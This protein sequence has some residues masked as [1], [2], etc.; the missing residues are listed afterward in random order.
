MTDAPV[1]FDEIGYWSELKLEIIK[2]YGE[3][4]TKAFARHPTLKKLY[5]DGFSGAGVHLSKKTKQQ[6][7]GSP[8]LALKVS[9]PFDAFY[10]VDM[11]SE[12]IAYLRKLCQGRSDVH[13]H[14]GI[15]TRI[16]QHNYCRRSGIR[17]TSAPCACSIPTGC[18]SI[19]GHA[20]SR[21][22]KGNRHVSQFPCHGHE[23]ERDLAY[24]GECPARR[25]RTHEPLLGGRVMARCCLCR[26]RPRQ[27]F[28]TRT[29]QTGQ[30][31]DCESVSE[32]TERRR[33]I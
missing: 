27:F 18:I 28:W 21:P 16:S 26:K 15:Q 24:P 14:E 29:C 23:Q 32:A 22:V 20:A 9:P 30:R 3:A 19:G 10:F 7:E 17:T 25:Y 5:I 1:K 33:R 13:F 12:K 11:D 8:A 4:Y 31:R 2:K 6:I